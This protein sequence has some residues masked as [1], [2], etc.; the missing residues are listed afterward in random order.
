M[1]QSAVPCRILQGSE[2]LQIEPF[3]RLLEQ[4]GV[5]LFGATTA[6]EFAILGETER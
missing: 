2:N 6:V 1:T 4:V 3:M 5:N